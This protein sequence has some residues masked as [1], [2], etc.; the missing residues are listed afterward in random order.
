MLQAAPLKSTRQA[1][2]RASPAVRV[3]S[4]RCCS[5]RLLPWAGLPLADHRHR[6]STPAVYHNS[7]IANALA[8]CMAL[9]IRISVSTYP[10]IRAGQV[11]LPAV[12]V[13]HATMVILL[14]LSRLPYHRPSL[15][16][17]LRCSTW[18]GPMASISSSQR[19]LRPRI[20]IVPFGGGRQVAQIDRVDWQHAARARACD[21]ARD[22]NAIVADFS[23]E[24]PDE[25]EAFLAD[26]ALDGR[27]VYQVQ[28]L[29]KSLTGR[30]AGPAS[31]GE[32][33]RQPGPGARLFGD[34]A[35][36]RLPAGG[37]GAAAGCCR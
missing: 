30:V 9:W 33:L 2:V 18:S 25:W 21:A 5:R 19:R 8:I 34:Q 17:R 3:R 35:S 4:G 7:L 27:M 13:G 16:A 12:F 6:P 37:G 22:C 14:L 24:L 36:R 1:G 32:Q 15:G 11:I 29:S 26:A 31:V 10:G 20:A 28:Q 23:A